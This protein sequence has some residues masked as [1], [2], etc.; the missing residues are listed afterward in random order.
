MKRKEAGRQQL[1]DFLERKEREKAGRR[2]QNLESQKRTR[3]EIRKLNDVAGWSKVAANV[4]LKQGE[5]PGSKD[6]TR[7]REAIINKKSDESK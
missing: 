5:H 1:E 6:T 3:E 2:E 7:M 4:P